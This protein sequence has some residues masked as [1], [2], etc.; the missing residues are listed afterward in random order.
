MYSLFFA[1]QHVQAI[2]AG[3]GRALFHFTHREMLSPNTLSLWGGFISYS[4]V[5]TERE[6]L[7]G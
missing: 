5:L 2:S 4:L 6:Q 7:S 3:Q 1:F